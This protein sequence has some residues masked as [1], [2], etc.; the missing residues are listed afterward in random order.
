M[1]KFSKLMVLF[2]CSTKC[3]VSSEIAQ[4]NVLQ[5]TDID[6]HPITELIWSYTCVCVC[7]NERERVYQTKPFEGQHIVFSSLHLKEGNTIQTEVIL[8]FMHFLFLVK[9]VKRRIKKQTLLVCNRWAFSLGLKTLYGFVSFTG[10]GG[11]QFQNFK[12]NQN[13]VKYN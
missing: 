12:T 11:W 4:P 10:G 3:N 13:Q 6:T 5:S 7:V 8:V 2:S 1:V 9:K